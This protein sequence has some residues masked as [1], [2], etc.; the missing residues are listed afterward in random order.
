MATDE[1]QHAFWHC[2]DAEEGSDDFRYKDTILQVYVRLDEAIG[3]LIEQANQIYSDQKLITIILSDHGAGPFEWMINLNRWLADEG[4]LVFRTWENGRLQQWRAQSLKHAA[5]LYRNYISA[6]TRTKI[7]NLLGSNQFTNIKEGF[8]SA[9]LTSNVDWEHT[10]AYSLGAGGNIYI[11]VEGREPAGIVQPN[12]EY[13]Q[14]RNEIIKKLEQLADPVTG[15]VVIK[16]IHKREELYHGP[17]LENAP[18]LI[19]EW[20]DYAYW[21]R[22]RYDNQAPVFEK[23]R[24][25]DFSAQPLTGSHRPEGILILQGDNVHNDQQI[26]NAKIVDLAPT[27]LSLLGIRP[28]ENMDG[29]ILIEAFQPQ[30]FADLEMLEEIKIEKEQINV[31]AKDEGKITDHLRSLGY[32]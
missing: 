22:G 4:Y 12:E 10:K 13:D 25:F 18:D 19:I 7:R 16:K 20:R 1:V 31:Q 14:L 5:N 8:E 21:G 26:S 27:I 28:P 17:H 23:Q 32:L 29:R 2:M 6:Q 15:E 11:N 24:K 3:K 9:L 30:T